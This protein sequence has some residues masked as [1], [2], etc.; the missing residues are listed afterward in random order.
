MLKRVGVCQNHNNYITGGR[1]SCRQVQHSTFCGGTQLTAHDINR[2]NRC[3]IY[4]YIYLY[5]A[6]SEGLEPPQVRTLKAHDK[7]EDRVGI[8]LQQ[9]AQE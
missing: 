1:C 6:H 3:T 4:V 2:E 7:N 5:I 8:S 9:L